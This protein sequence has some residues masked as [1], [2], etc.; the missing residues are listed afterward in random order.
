MVVYVCITFIFNKR[1]SSVVEQGQCKHLLTTTTLNTDLQTSISSY[2]SKI[3]SVMCGCE[4]ICSSIC[5][6]AKNISI[7]LSVYEMQLEIFADVKVPWEETV[8]L[9]CFLK[10][11]FQ[12][13]RLHFQHISKKEKCLQ[14]QV[15]SALSQY[16]SY[17]TCSLSLKSLYIYLI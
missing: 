13:V 9:S 12:T 11:N 10:M 4:N 15:L 8:V 6:Q 3:E 14:N 16:P 1:N 17:I 5:S 2:S 7:C